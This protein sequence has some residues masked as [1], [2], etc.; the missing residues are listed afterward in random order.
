[1]QHVY[2]PHC[3]ERVLVDNPGD[4]AQ[5]TCPVCLRNIDADLDEAAPKDYQAHAP[6][7]EPQKQKEGKE[8]VQFLQD[9]ARKELDKKPYHRKPRRVNLYAGLILIGIG[10]ALL[11]RE[12]MSG[13]GMMSLLINGILFSCVFF[14]CGVACLMFHNK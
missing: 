1:M 6:V 9:R 10:L 11:V 3:L 14:L 4:G 13:D 7:V 2:C 12:I 5:R 8:Y